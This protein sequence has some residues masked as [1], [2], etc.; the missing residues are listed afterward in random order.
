M[1]MHHLPTLM[2]GSTLDIT[3]TQMATIILFLSVLNLNIR[4]MPNKENNNISHLVKLQNNPKASFAEGI[5]RCADG[6]KCVFCMY[7]NNH[8]IVTVEM[9]SVSAEDEY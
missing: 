1:V 4:L 5:K 7:K 2:P 6:G 3:L 9:I 8:N